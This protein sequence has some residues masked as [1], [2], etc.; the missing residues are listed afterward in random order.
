MNYACRFSLLLLSSVSLTSCLQEEGPTPINLVQTNN[1]IYLQNIVTKTDNAVTKFNNLI[2]QGNVIVDFYADWCG[3]CKAMSSVIGQLA[4]Q[5]PNVTFLKVN[6]D[7]FPEISSSIR[8]IP[9]IVFYKNG[10]QVHRQSGA[11]TAQQMGA[12]IRKLF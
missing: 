4:A 3:P 7:M 5:Y 10:Q 12:L 6:T 9:T 11:L 1:V 2:K 8:S